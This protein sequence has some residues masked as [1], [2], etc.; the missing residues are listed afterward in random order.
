[1]L[2]RKANAKDAKNAKIA[3]QNARTFF[4]FAFF[5]YLALIPQLARGWGLVAHFRTTFEHRS[6]AAWPK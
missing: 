5:A 2:R 1:M 4:A 6:F 3:E